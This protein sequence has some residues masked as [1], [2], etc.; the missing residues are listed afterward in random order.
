MNIIK[1]KEVIEKHAIL[2]EKTN[3]S[4]NIS[5]NFGTDV[6]IYRS[7][8]HIIY[9][10]GNQE[11]IHISEIA[12]K[13]GVTKGAVSKA[14]RKL[15]VKNLVYKFVDSTNKTRVLVK[16]TEK[17]R[18]AYKNHEMYHR[19]YD[20]EMFQFLDNLSESELSVLSRFLDKANDMAGRHI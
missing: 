17:G 2:V 8:I 19:E 14:I 9:V 11:G 18:L 6:E 15:E 16:L 20:K 1:M 4:I 12:R 5:R 7:E 13:F 3:S 10:I